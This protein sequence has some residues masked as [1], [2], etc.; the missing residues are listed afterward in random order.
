MLSTTFFLGRL[1]IDIGDN[2]EQRQ[3]SAEAILAKRAFFF[4]GEGLNIKWSNTARETIRKRKQQP[5]LLVRVELS[6]ED[7][8]G[9]LKISGES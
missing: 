3:K 6:E 2:E 1:A 8:C 4:F 9:T 5:I 7:K